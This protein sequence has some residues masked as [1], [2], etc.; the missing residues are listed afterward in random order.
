MASVSDGPRL[1]LPWGRGASDPVFQKLHETSTLATKRLG[2]LSGIDRHL[3]SPLFRVQADG[4][5]DVTV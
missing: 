1:E 5:L 3:V 4:C 2:H